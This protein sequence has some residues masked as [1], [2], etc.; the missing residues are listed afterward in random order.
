MTVQLCLAKARENTAACGFHKEFQ[1]RAPRW[2]GST[3]H[4]ATARIDLGVGIALKVL[5]TRQSTVLGQSRR[6]EKSLSCIA[7]TLSFATAK[8]TKSIRP[9]FL[10]LK[11]VNLQV[12]VLTLFLAKVLVVGLL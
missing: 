3:G 5:R 6:L 1:C 8:V 7:I 4:R 10:L 9:Q 11:I 2:V 12:F